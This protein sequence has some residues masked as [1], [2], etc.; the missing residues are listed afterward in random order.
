MSMPRASGKAMSLQ[1]LV[2]VHGVIE[3]DRKVAGDVGKEE[4]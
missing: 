3:C 4:R 2:A 1:P